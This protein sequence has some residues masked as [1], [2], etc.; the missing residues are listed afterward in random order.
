MYWFARWLIFLSFC[1]QFCQRR[2]SIKWYGVTFDGWLW[3][4]F[5]SPR[6][7]PQS[8]HTRGNFQLQLQRTSKWNW[9]NRQAVIYIYVRHIYFFLM[10]RYSFSS[11]YLSLLVGLFSVK[12]SSTLVMCNSTFLW[13]YCHSPDTWLASTYTSCQGPWL[14]GFTSYQNHGSCL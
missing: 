2:G 10:F 11:S 6:F 5:R 3:L 13:G 4:S 8:K 1:W 9:F 7:V 14:W 12:K